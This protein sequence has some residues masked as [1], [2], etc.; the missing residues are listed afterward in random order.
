MKERFEFMHYRRDLTIANGLQV[1][2]QDRKCLV[3]LAFGAIQIKTVLR[4]CCVHIR[5]AKNR[6]RLK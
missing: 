5:M 1:P 4:Y 3:S 2:T 6:K